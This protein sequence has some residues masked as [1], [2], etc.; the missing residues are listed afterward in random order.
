MVSDDLDPDVSRERSTNPKRDVAVIGLINPVG[1]IAL[2]RT[3]RLPNYW[4]PIGGGMEPW[5]KSPTDTLVREVREE[6]GIELTANEMTHTFSAGY[7]FGDGTIY[8]Y[9]A[10]VVD[11]TIPN[12]NI[13]E[14]AEWKWFTPEETE[15]LQTFPATRQ[16]LDHLLQINKT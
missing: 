8:F 14:I 4:Q 2:V 10:N 12:L 5:D 13:S 3:T 9:I 15:S 16:F 1:K 7:D 6:T 11:E